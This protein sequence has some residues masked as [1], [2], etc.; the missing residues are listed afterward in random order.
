MNKIR[1]GVIGCGKIGSKHGTI[2]NEL[3]DCEL[4]AVCDIIKERADFLSSKFNAKSYSDYTQLIICEDCDIVC[5]CTPS[6][7]HAEMTIEAAKNKKH[8][9]CEKPMSLNIKDAKKMIKACEENN[10]KLFIVKQNRF[11]Q[12]VEFLKQVLAK[13]RLGKIYLVSTNVFWNRRQEYYLEEDWRGTLKFDGGALFTQASHFIDLLVW[14]NGTVKSVFAKKDTFNHDIETEDTGAA[15]LKFENGS[16]A[17]FQY[18]TC[19][20]NTNY[21]GSITVFGTKGTIKIGGKYLNTIEHWNVEGWPEPKVTEN[22]T[23]NNYGNYV[24]SGSNH[25]KVFENIINHFRNNT[26]IK[27]DGYDAL[28]SVEIMEAIYKSA[29]EGKEIFLPLEFD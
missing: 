7:L 22:L 12:P 16:F 10:I 13:N 26:P 21:E 8:I 17:T 15:I 20:Y 9:L 18:T 6:G 23:P 2:I 27:T 4:I 1:F 14:V 5:I 19:V 28:Q 3:E 25:K 11:N 24:G 29:N